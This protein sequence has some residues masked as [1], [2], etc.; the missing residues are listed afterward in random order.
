MYILFRR[1]R[2]LK[3]IGFSFSWKD[4]RISLLLF[5]IIILASNLYDYIG[6]NSFRLTATRALNLKPKNIYLWQTPITIWYLF[7]WLIGPFYEELIVRAYLISEIEY[8]T[9]KTYLA[10]ILSIVLQT[11]YHLY[12]GHIS[13]IFLTLTFLIYSLYYV[14]W[15]RITPIIL[16]H[17]YWNIFIMLLHAR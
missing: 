3:E 12:L 9:R 16:S 13:V 14:K 1:G 4:F 10:V 11:S 7:Y 8:L 17:L 2:N 15:R 5:L 6:Y